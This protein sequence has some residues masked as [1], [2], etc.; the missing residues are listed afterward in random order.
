MYKVQL[1]CE[2]A[3][4]RSENDANNATKDPGL[5]HPHP[6]ERPDGAIW[7]CA[8]LTVPATCKKKKTHVI[9]DT[10]G[11]KD[12]NEEGKMCCKPSAK[13]KKSHV[14]RLNTLEG[15][16]NTQLCGTAVPQ[17]VGTRSSLLFKFSGVERNPGRLV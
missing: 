11:T 1:K 16:E 9:T 2:T 4:K 13:K 5:T 8:E 6:F 7:T 12:E 14:K 17:K 10:T 15:S 3:K